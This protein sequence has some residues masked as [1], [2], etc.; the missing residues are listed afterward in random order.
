MITKGI[1]YTAKKYFTNSAVLSW[2]LLVASYTF[3]GRKPSKPLI[4]RS[5]NFIKILPFVASIIMI[6]LIQKLEMTPYRHQIGIYNGSS[7]YIVSVQII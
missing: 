5:T 1:N 6:P 7:N 2:P 3:S 4:E